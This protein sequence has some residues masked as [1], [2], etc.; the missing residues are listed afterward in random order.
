[1]AGPEARKYSPTTRGAAM[2]TAD[3]V[4]RVADALFQIA[5]AQKALAA[6]AKRQANATEALLEAQKVNLAVSKA[7]EEE[8][9]RKSRD[10]DETS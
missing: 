3:G 6:Q 8:L 2:A 7:L 5:K 4:H 10:S 9:L 1:M